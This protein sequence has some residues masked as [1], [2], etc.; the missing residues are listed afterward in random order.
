MR[1]A[2]AA[3]VELIDTFAAAKKAGMSETVLD[4]ARKQHEIA[5]VLWEWWTAE[6]SDGW[7][8]P[9]LAKETLIDSI[10][11][12]KKGTEILKNAMAQK[13]AAK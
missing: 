8:N 9:K 10:V 1:K 3:I 4:Q 13:S 12:A 11:Q 6:N 5:H 7:H 2:E